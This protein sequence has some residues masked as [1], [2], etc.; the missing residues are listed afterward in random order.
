MQKNL[1]YAHS[2]LIQITLLMKTAL[3][4]KHY[5]SI[6]HWQRLKEQKQKEMGKLSQKRHK[7]EK[8]LEK[9]MIRINEFAAARIERW[10]Y[11]WCFDKIM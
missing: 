7:E 3:L 5:V 10:A 2:V 8:K 9:E 4:A 11:L 6:I 1:L